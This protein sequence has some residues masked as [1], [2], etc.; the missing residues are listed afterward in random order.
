MKVYRTDAD[1]SN[2]REVRGPGD[3][4][5][6]GPNDRLTVVGPPPGEREGSYGAWV[7]S[8]GYA[9]LLGATV[10]RIL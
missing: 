7:Q 5:G 9:A 1:G 3:L 8:L 2:R 6:V 4:I 10:R